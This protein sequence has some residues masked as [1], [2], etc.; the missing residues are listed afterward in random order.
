MKISE[1]FSLNK[2]QQELDFVDI[3][4][5]CDMPLFLDPY[6]IS[7]RKSDIAE[8]GLQSIQSFFELLITYLKN[9]ECDMAQ[10]LMEHVGEINEIHLGLSKNKSQGRGIGS[11]DTLRLIESLKNS[12][13]LETGLI[14]NLEDCRLFIENI[15]KDKIS[16]LCANIMKKQLIDYT[17]DQC[18]LWNIPLQEAPSGFYWDFVSRKWTQ[19]LMC[20]RLIINGKPILLVPKEFVSYSNSYCMEKYFQHFVLNFYQNEHLRLD[21]ALVRKKIDKNGKVIRRWVTKNSIRDDFKLKGITINKAWLVEFSTNHPEIIDE[22]RKNAKIDDL[23][24]FGSEV[25]PNKLNGIIDSI[26]TK[27]QK[28]PEGKD[29]ATEYHNLIL[30]ACE[31]LFYPTLRNPKK[32]F[33]INEGRK[34]IDIVFSNA[35]Q[36]GIFKT[37]CEKFKISLNILMIECKNYNKEIANPELDQM[38]GRLCYNRG[39]LG[40]IFCRHL[41]NEALFI[42]REQDTFI[43]ENK[44]IIHIT[45]DRLIQLLDTYRDFFDSSYEELISKW[46]DEVCKSNSE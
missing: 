35:A 21:T 28:I 25:T 20:K 22:Y 27:L 2:T 24:V 23:D 43:D 14:E 45:D 6:F 36:T 40:I 4:Y 5:D 1:Y 31:F 34:R 15:G 9:D 37:L 41:D 11:D 3:D 18:K 16:D 8:E 10:A 42:K 38:S 17:I 7:R 44:I 32:E 33:E 29:Y 26:I 30:G 12:K 46:I 19:D 39:M 13:A